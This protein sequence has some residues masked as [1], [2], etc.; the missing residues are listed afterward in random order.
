MPQS[1]FEQEAQHGNSSS[2]LG[3]LFGV[4]L[5][6]RGC[7]GVPKSW[8][9][10]TGKAIVGR[11]LTGSRKQWLHRV[12]PLV[13][14][15][16]SEPNSWNCVIGCRDGVTDILECVSSIELALSGDRNSVL[17]VSLSKLVE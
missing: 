1:Y 5:N 17:P 6:T 3:W 4:Q 13:I 11:R 7:V 2:V 16:R 10:C 9:W 8:N 14:S 15:V 12:S